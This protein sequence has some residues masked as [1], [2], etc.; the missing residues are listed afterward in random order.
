MA[1]LFKRGRFLYLSFYDIVGRHCQRSLRIP[2]TQAGW[3]EA[4]EIKRQIEANLK[5]DPWGI[6]KQIRL[7][8]SRKRISELFQQVLDFGYMRSRAPGTVG[9]AKLSV[10]KFIETIGDLPISKLTTLAMIQ[11][12]EAIIQRDGE[13]NTAIWLRTLGGVFSYARK[14]GLLESNPV[15]EEVRI[16]PK[17]RP[18]IAMR[19]EEVERFFVKAGELHGARF[20]RQCRFLY[21]TGFRVSDGCD[22][23]RSDIDFEAGIILYRNKKAKTVT[24]FPIYS[25][26]EP[27]LEPAKTLMPEECVFA[28]QSNST[29]SHYFKHVIN[30]LGLNKNYSIHTLKSSYITRLANAGVKPA[31]LQRL[32]HHADYRTTDQY[33]IAQEIEPLRQ[34]LELLAK[35]AAK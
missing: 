19:L 29:M 2:A 32:A 5:R 13:Q 33:Y 8:T 3:R 17:P 1:S 11:F 27:I 20:V 16:K 15:T 12:R 4:K 23:R 7:A 34:D 6:A 14:L 25:L 26:L 28:F 22:F 30:A 18:P 10:R 9:L 31:H 24:P 21:L 35:I